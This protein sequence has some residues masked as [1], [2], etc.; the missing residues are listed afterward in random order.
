MIDNALGNKGTTVNGGFKRSWECKSAEVDLE[1]KNIN[2]PSFEILK[3]ECRILLIFAH[4]FWRFGLDVRFWIT[5]RWLFTVDCLRYL[6]LNCY[7][8]FVNWFLNEGQF[9]L[10]NKRYWAINVC[11]MFMNLTYCPRHGFPRTS[12]ISY[13]FMDSKNKN[14]KKTNIQIWIMKSSRIIQPKSHSSGKI[15]ANTIKWHITW[16]LTWPNSN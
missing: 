9:L 6:N 2:E 8:R 5:S 14:R 7:C 13:R 10:K 3:I 1:Q 4:D 16:R 12:I 11:E 15:D